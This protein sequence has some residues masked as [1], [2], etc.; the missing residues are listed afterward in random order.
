M[1]SQLVASASQDG[2][3]RLWDR[4]GKLVRVLPG[5]DPVFSL[6][7][8]RDGT[9]LATGAIKFP[10]SS[11]TG[12]AQLPG[13]I[14]L[15]RPDGTLLH[16]VGTQSTGGKFINLAWS[17]DGRLLAAGASDYIDWRADGS[18]SA[19]VRQGGTP[20]WAMAWS[21]DGGT[22][23][24]GDES[25]VLQLVD[26]GGT[27]I[28][29]GQFQGDVNALSY[30]PD[31]GGLIV[32]LLGKIQLVHP[33]DPQNPAHAIWSA[34][35][36]DEGHVAWS[37]D[38]DRLAIAVTDGLAILSA[39]GSAVAALTGCPGDPVAFAWTGASLAAATSQGNL[40]AWHA[41]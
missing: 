31:G 10:S 22:I 9:I 37:P 20:A 24:L 4:K 35:T 16:T 12:L 28:G 25:G 34:D 32:G 23:A 17:P 3:V 13:I 8:S 1:D 14:K 18:Q 30:V 33:L 2:S 39:D 21:P 5:I 19:I 7:W 26:A 38:G 40:C 27:S 11:A 41:P 29:D 15:W 36:A 6:A